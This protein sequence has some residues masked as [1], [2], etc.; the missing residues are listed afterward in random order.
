MKRKQY[1]V[2]YGMMDGVPSLQICWTDYD[3]VQYATTMWNLAIYGKD[4]T[5]EFREFDES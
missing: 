5:V 1:R 4:F 2:F 3:P